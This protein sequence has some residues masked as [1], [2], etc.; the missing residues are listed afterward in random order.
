[1]KKR[2][3]LLPRVTIR[4]VKRGS[5]GPFLKGIVQDFCSEVLLR[6]QAVHVLPAVDNSLD[7]FFVKCLNNQQL[8]ML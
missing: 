3:F 2:L 8:K 5:W 1:M 6:C 4:W 7:V